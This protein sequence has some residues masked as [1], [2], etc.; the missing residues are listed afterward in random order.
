M[1]LD[2]HVF[3]GR[4]MNES[5]VRW[6]M[7]SVR[8]SPQSDGFSGCPPPPYLFEASIVEPLRVSACSSR[9]RIGCSHTTGPREHAFVDVNRKV[10]GGARG[11]L[12][13]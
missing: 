4:P 2:I 11:S 3:V 8:I 1:R 9:C 6:K 10:E 7:I 12:R 13:V 5:S